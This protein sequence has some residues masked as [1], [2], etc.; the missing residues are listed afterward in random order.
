[1]KK[2]FKSLMM[3]AAAAMTLAGCEKEAVSENGNPEVA[4][5]KI[6]VKATVKSA[7]T[8][9][10]LSE[11]DGKYSNA[12]DEGDA[13]DIVE[14][15]GKPGSITEE[16]A[17][18]VV[19]AENIE[20]ADEL[21]M[22]DFTLD[23][24]EADVFTYYAVYPGGNGDGLVNTKYQ[25]LVLPMPAEQKPTAESLVDPRANVVI[26]KAEV[27]EQATE[28][29]F[30]ESFYA[31]AY[32]RMTIKGLPEGVTPKTVK[33]ENKTISDGYSVNIAG[34][35]WY[36]LDG[37]YAAA[38]GA[39]APSA[40]TTITVD[41]S[42]AQDPYVVWF[43]LAPIG[44]ITDFV[45]TVTGSDD[46]EYVKSVTGASTLDF[47]AGEI[48]KFNVTVAEVTPE[49]PVV[50]SKIT[51][52]A[53]FGPGEYII[54]SNVSGNSYA[55]ATT[56]Y[57]SSHLSA[58]TV[59]ISGQFV[60]DPDSKYIWTIEDSETSGE[61]KLNSGTYYLGWSS[62]TSFSQSNNLI[63]LVSNKEGAFGFANTAD[64]S[65]VIQYNGSADFRPYSNR[66]ACGLT[67]FK[68][69]V[70]SEITPILT[71]DKS[72]L[73]FEANSVETQVV[74]LSV[75]DPDNE[76]VS[77]EWDN[78][79]D[80]YAELADNI[81]SVNPTSENTTTDDKTATLTVSLGELSQ[82]IKI[83]QKGIIP[84]GTE[85][86][87][88]YT[89]A[90]TSSVS[91]DGTEPVGSSATYNQTYSTKNQLTGGNNATLTLSGYDGKII[92][93][94]VLNMRSNA[95]AG[96][97]TFSA[98]A[99]DTTLA[100]I[101]TATTFDKWY[102]NDEYSSNYKDITVTMT[103]STYEVKNSEK[104][105]IKIDATTNSLYINSYTITYIDGK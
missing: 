105:V 65:R 39:G 38:Y 30:D 34:C 51:T 75:I 1:M 102:D 40:T 36:M 71:V 21:A 69:V 44:K 45:V 52:M 95:K 62:G 43:G 72:E 17:Y 54:A 70:D 84:A 31:A 10:S 2:M 99:G 104:V 76:G 91:K 35:F 14:L 32:A 87:V 81:I 3:F 100:E 15:S 103:N 79:V 63:W 33:F 77:I 28:L 73:V 18:Q 46:K 74:T 93:G 96:A 29:Y 22:F 55:I 6:T 88:T 85:K 9:V 90:S 20:T 94:I 82:T 86:T 47:T 23:K 7:A 24:S 12:W 97:G 78:K 66:G 37:T 80:F 26:A 49:A 92:T 41:Q 53:E 56:T 50:F 89:V 5:E 61:Y 67:L 58:E 101:S 98:K 59:N 60:I 27:D 48:I 4:V 13:I 57:T 19:A 25:E 68:K 83:T 64:D 42:E 8:R 16:T 11:T